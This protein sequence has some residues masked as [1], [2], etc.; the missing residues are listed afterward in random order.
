VIQLPQL[1]APAVPNSAGLLELVSNPVFGT[2]TAQ[3][4]TNETVL[5]PLGTFIFTA[6]NVPGEVNNLV[7]MN[8]TIDG[9]TPSANNVT[10]SGIVLDPLL[11]PGTATITVTGSVVPE[12]SGPILMLAVLASAGTHSRWMRQSGR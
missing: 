8:T 10:A 6:D 4:V 3:T 12:P 7:A 9:T 2:I 1:P 5:L 11:Q